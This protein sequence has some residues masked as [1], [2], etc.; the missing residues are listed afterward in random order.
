[1]TRLLWTTLGIFS[2]G[3]GAIGVILP[4]LPTTPLVLL[5]AFAFTKGSPRFR[6]RLVEHRVFGPIIADWEINGAIARRYKIM[7]CVA[8]GVVLLGSILAQL[9]AV[10]LVVQIVCMGAGATYVLTRP[11]CA[12]PIKKR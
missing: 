6:Q 12:S 5:A 9:S 2:L 11:S 8:M 7:A 4:L 1:M 10:I 3:L